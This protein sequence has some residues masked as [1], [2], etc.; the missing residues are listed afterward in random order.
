MRYFF[1]TVSWY[2][3]SCVF[4]LFYILKAGFLNYIIY[5][6]KNIECDV[7]VIFKKQGT[8]TEILVFQLHVF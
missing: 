8:S 2:K 7:N 1:P 6:E 4:V 5:K 3:L